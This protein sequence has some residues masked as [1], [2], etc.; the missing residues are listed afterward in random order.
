MSAVRNFCLVSVALCLLLVSSADA[1]PSQGKSKFP[2]S[3]CLSNDGIASKSC[4]GKNQC[5][6]GQCAS[7]TCDF[8][9]GQT[10]N[11]KTCRKF[12]CDH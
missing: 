9:I 1:A 12:C 2:G 8:S 10:F 3:G 4:G 6:S 7:G 5:S 11:D